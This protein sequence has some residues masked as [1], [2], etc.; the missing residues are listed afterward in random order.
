MA[1]QQQALLYSVADDRY[2]ETPSRLADEGER[3]PL[4][5]GQFPAGWIRTDQGLWTALRPADAAPVEQGWK[6]HLSATPRTAELTLERAAAVLFEH[7]VPFK[8]LR[9]RRA[10]ELFSGKQMHRGASGKFIAAYP[11]DE[12]RLAELL[13]A[14][15]AA[16]GGLPGPYILSDLRIGDGPV[17]VRY[18]AYVDLWC[19][20]ADGTAVPALRDPAGRLVPDPRGPVF[21][22]P[23][24]VS[25]PP[26]LEPHLLARAQARDDDFPYLMRK[27]LHFSNAGGIYLAEHRVT[28]RRV[29]LREARPFAGLDGLGDAVERLHR[30]YRTLL[31][32]RGLDCVPTVYGLHTVWEHSYLVEEYIEGSTLLEEMVERHPVA[33]RD[34]GPEALRSYARW[35]ESVAASLRRALDAIH[36]R[37]ICFR[38]VHPSNI[39]LRP[40][41]SLALIDFEYASTIDDPDL[42]RVGARGFRAPTGATGLEADAYGVWATWLAMLMPITEMIE[43]A[44]EKAALL[45]AAA[46]RRFGPSG[47]ERPRRPGRPEPAAVPE[48]PDEA[49]WPALR[50]ALIAGIHGCATPDREDRLYPADWAVFEHGGHTLAHGAAGVLLALARTGAPIPA[51]HV[52]WLAAACRRARTGIPRGLHDGL[53][54]SALVLDELGRPEQAREAFDRAGAA[55]LAAHAGIHGGQAGAALAH[56]H[57]AESAGDAALLDEA[58]RTGER[59]DALARGEAPSGL[60]APARAGLL[61]GFSG[62]ALLHLRLHELTGERRWLPAARRALARDI[63]HCVAMPDGTVMVRQGHRHLPYLDEG[64]CGIALAAGDYLEWAEDPSLATFIDRARR[65]GAS[66]FV[67]EPGLWRGRAGLL[68]AL[69]VLGPEGC[70][71]ESARSVA[72]LSWHAVRHRGGVLFPGYGLHKLS[73]DLAGGAAGVLLALHTVFDAKGARAALLPA[74]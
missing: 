32:L 62:A 4:T 26:V 41:G 10:V 2:F 9:S 54:G 46:V 21:R 63:E 25:P 35:A 15:T 34:C 61:Y 42:P 45:E 33:G 14:L 31:A 48:P 70:E 64:S 13:A 72:D 1:H 29:V 71:E 49:D 18:G 43:F 65:L 6:I 28:G 73:A 67:R 60:I 57:F 3:Y 8:F 17:H 50:A 27:A 47:A 30:E 7:R 58:V 20:D 40:D 56:C 37:G 23:E 44:P 19:T 16:V 55:G 59:L 22:T 53:Y 12:T 68:A 5:D 52:D 74:I 39:I 69:A 51:E 36:E 66:E 24:W 11:A 38:D